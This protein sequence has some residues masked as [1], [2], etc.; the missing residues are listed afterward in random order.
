MG[1]SRTSPEAIAKVERVAFLMSLRFQG[2]TFREI[3]MMMTP[4]VSMQAAHKAFWKA[5]RSIPFDPARLR[6]LAAR[7]RA[8]LTAGT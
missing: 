2:H 3:G 4:P 5:M 8:A 7:E 1:K 6:R